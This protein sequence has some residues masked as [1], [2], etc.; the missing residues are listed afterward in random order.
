MLRERAG[1]P[2][3]LRLVRNGETMTRV[4][5]LGVTATTQ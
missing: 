3:R 1:H 2:V 4:V 5:R